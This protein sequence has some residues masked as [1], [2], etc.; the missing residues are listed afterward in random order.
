MRCWWAYLTLSRLDITYAVHQ[1]SQF[2][3]PTTSIPFTSNSPSPLLSQNNSWL[4]VIFCF[5][6]FNAIE[7]LLWCWLALM[8][9]FKKIHYRILCL[10]GDSVV[11]W[12]AK[13]QSTVARSIADAE[14]RELATITSE[15]IWLCQLLKD[16][17]IILTAPILLFCDNQAAIHIANPTFH[18]RTN[19][20][21]IDCHFVRNKIT[22]GLLKLMPI[23]SQHQ[24]ADISTKP[25]LS[26]LLFFM[27]SKMAVKN[28]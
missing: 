3:L 19:H 11:S 21:K 5:I 22:E 26:T 25:L 24:L 12:K 18:E 13:K 16:F 27:L 28:I 9:W 7:S 8:C 15:L 14:Y 20:I 2:S 23:R 4:R 1:L 6:F 17:G 10:L